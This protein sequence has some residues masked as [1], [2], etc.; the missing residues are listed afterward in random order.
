MQSFVELRTQIANPNRTIELG[1]AT[2]QLPGYHILSHLGEGGMGIVYKARSIAS[3]QLVAIKFMRTL[4][5]YDL[6]LLA[7]FR[8]E[9]EAVACLR[10]EN[11]VPVLEIGTFA[12]HPYLALEYVTGGDLTAVAR[13]AT[14]S[15]IWSA[16]IAAGVA[17][18]LHHSHRLGILHRDLKPQN[19]L[20]GTDGTPRI[21]DFG[22]AKFT[23][24]RESREKL[25]SASILPGIRGSLMELEQF[26]PDGTLQ[27]RV[28]EAARHAFAEC[29]PQY[30]ET[31]TEDAVRKFVTGAVRDAEAQDTRCFDHELTKQGDILGTPAYMAPEQTIGDIAS[32]GPPTDI[33]SLGV[34]LYEM[35][36]GQLPH[37][38]TS[39]AELFDH[40]RNKAPKPMSR[41]IPPKL[42]AIC[43]RCLSKTVDERFA[44]A[45]HLAEELEQFVDLAEA[46]L[47]DERR[48]WQFWR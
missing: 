46:Q 43:T 20:V 11:I 41:G 32:Y 40:I 4:T 21:T 33:Y 3:D 6:A 23:V 44:S 17:R 24:T 45:A 14:P 16:R 8:I 12:G 38:G 22:L 39:V 35:L 30:T 47:P 2:P 42:V 7:R 26:T 31:I 15:P 37:G 48:W 9:A 36:C 25:R 19:I 29:G 10:H 1:T 34:V 28:E 27:E 13:T 18:G 5:P